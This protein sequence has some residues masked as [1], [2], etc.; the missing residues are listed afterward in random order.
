MCLPGWP[1]C[2]AYP[3]R[4]VTPDP[5]PRSLSGDPGQPLGENAAVS[6]EAAGAGP[7][8]GGHPGTHSRTRPGA[9]APQKGWPL[10][11]TQATSQLKGADT[12]PLAV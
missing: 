12:E 10:E 8:A 6:G 4:S 11:R 5:A 3:S 2:P 9:L 1:R 7:P